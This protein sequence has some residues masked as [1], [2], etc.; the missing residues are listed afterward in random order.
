MKPEVN[1]SCP[2]RFTFVHL[3]GLLAAVQTETKNYPRNNSFHQIV[4]KK[5]GWTVGRVS[6]RSIKLVQYVLIPLYL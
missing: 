4:P 3:I 1:F 6:C 2:L 5:T